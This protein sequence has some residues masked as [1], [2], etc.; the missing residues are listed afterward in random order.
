VP[1]LVDVDRTMTCHGCKCVCYSW[2]TMC[3]NMDKHQNQMRAKTRMMKKLAIYCVV[4]CADG[5]DQANAAARGDGMVA[6]EFAA[7]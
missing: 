7:R 6:W 5:C 2:P 3:A 4:A 1:D